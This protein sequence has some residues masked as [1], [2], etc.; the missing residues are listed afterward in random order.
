MSKVRMEVAPSD[1]YLSIKGIQYAFHEAIADLVD[2]SIDAEATNVWIKASKDVIII[3]DNGN[4][5]S[6]PELAVAIT[7][8][9]AGKKDMKARRGKRGK[10][11]IGMKSASYSLGE[12]LEIHTKQDGHKFE[13]LK[14]DRSEIAEIDDP[15]HEFETD[16]VSTDLFKQ[17]TKNGSGTV[18]EITDVNRR[19]VTDSAI[20][21]LRNLLGLVYFSLIESGEVSIMINDLA[22]KPLDPL[23]RGLKKN[24]P[25]NKYELFDKKSVHVEFDGRKATFKIQGA[26]VGRGAHWTDDDKKTY[27]Y[28]LKRNPTENDSTKSGL[29]KLDEQGIY[30]LRNGRLI[31]LGGWLGLASQNTLL[32]HNTSTRILLEFDETGDDLMGLDNTKTLLKIEEALKDKLGA[33]V[34]EVVSDGE[35][36]FRREGEIILKKREKQKASETIKSLTLR[37]DSA[38][39]Q[40][41][42]DERRK[43]SDPDF[44][45][46]QKDLELEQDEE[47][48]GTDELAVVL[49]RLPYNNLWGYDI[50]KEGEVLL[51]LNSDHPGFAALFLEQDEE[52][53]RKNLRHFFYT[54]AL[55][56]YSLSDLHKE[57]K[58]AILSEL[59]DAFKTFRR[60]VS[61]HFTEF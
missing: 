21:S 13:Y 12:C 8:W 16:N 29:L 36:N 47:A 50:N 3:A 11:G 35:R 30:T 22:V 18:L 28:F 52:T 14:L 41:K 56:E 54:L 45:K 51:T 32:H 5:M 49:D 48:K 4:G 43:K 44:E 25:G 61:K 27:R 26:Y 34:R 60:W 40:Y 58:P 37:K 9:R 59:E 19:K 17:Y 46:R 7:P 23:M 15:D 57:K 20:E 39:A 24:A 53:V 38:L 6:L 31:T 2:N 55:H 33:Y 1:L 10:F 42:M